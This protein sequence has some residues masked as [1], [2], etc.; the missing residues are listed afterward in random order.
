M[1]TIDAG[2]AEIEATCTTATGHMLPVR[3]GSAADDGDDEANGDNDATDAGHTVVEFT[4][5]SCEPHRLTVTYGG[6]PVPGTPIT[7]DVC[8]AADAAA[9][10]A[11]PYANQSHINNHNNQNNN[12]NNGHS[13]GNLNNGQHHSNGNGRNGSG[14]SATIR[15]S[16]TGLEVAHRAKEAAFTVFCPGTPNVQI[17]RVDEAGDRVEPR[18]KLVAAAGAGSGNKGGASEWRVAYTLLSV[19]MYEIRVSCPARG[20]LPGSPW[21]VNAVDTNKVM[22]VGGWGGHLDGDGRLVLPARFVFDISAQAGP[23]ELVCTVDGRELGELINKTNQFEV[24][25]SFNSFISK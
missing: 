14:D 2:H 4:P 21:R 17:E 24:W 8:S 1:S 11:T 15:A 6:E 7:F 5:H 13:I 23:G 20:A 22:P 25:F 19:G 9:A 10:V 3:I 16:G 12:N 18:V